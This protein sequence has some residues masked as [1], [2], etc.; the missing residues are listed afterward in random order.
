V[1][2]RQDRRSFHPV[3]DFSVLVE[4]PAEGGAIDDGARMRVTGRDTLDTGDEPRYRNRRWPIVVAR[5]V[6]NR[7]ECIRAPTFE[8]AGDDRSGMKLA[9]Y[10]GAR[11]A[12]DIDGNRQNAIAGASVAELPV[13]IVSPAIHRTVG[14]NCAGVHAA[15]RYLR[16]AREHGLRE[17]CI[18]HPERENGRHAQRTGPVCNRQRHLNP[19]LFPE[20]QNSR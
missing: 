6:S 7:A 5:T 10:N 2:R 18:C 19:P 11:H 4:T 9:R 16:N 3:A 1:R 15:S 20:L 14:Q 13:D 12:V 17:R 8:P